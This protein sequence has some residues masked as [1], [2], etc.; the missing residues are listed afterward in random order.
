M[1]I[2]TVSFIMRRM[3]STVTPSCLKVKKRLT[4]STTVFLPTVV[5]DGF[6]R[7]DH[8]EVG[9]TTALAVDVPSHCHPKD[10]RYHR[11][12]LSSLMTPTLSSSKSTWTAPTTL[13]HREISTTTT[14]TTTKVETTTETT[15][16][17]DDDDDDDVASSIACVSSTASD[18]HVNDNNNNNDYESNDDSLFIDSTY[19]AIHDS[20]TGRHPSPPPPPPPPPVT[21]SEEWI[22]PPP[23]PSLQGG[24]DRAYRND[25][26]GNDD[27][28]LFYLSEEE[29]DTLSEEEILQRLEDVLSR[30]EQEE[31]E[32]QDELLL[33]EELDGPSSPVDWMQNRRAIL[34]TSRS[35]DG[36]VDPMSS[37]D[38]VPIRVHELMTV[39]EIQTLLEVHGGSDVI[40]VLDDVDHP[41]MGGALGM[42]IC[43]SGQRRGAG[44][45]ASSSSPANLDN[46]SSNN[47]TIDS[48]YPSSP[49]SG[50][51]NHSSYVISTLTRAL[52]EH[53]K[54]RR[55][56]EAGMLGG[57]LPTSA[58]LS[59]SNRRRNNW[60]VIDC[61]NYI[62]HILDP[63]TRRALRL[64]E[65]WSGRDPLWKLDVT[66][67]DAVEDYCA[68]YPVPADYGGQN[69]S[70]AQQQL[71]MWD[72]R[73][74]RRLERNQYA[75]SPFPSHRPVVP[76]ATKKR[77]RRAGKRRLREQRQQQQ[78]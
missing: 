46:N 47:A 76:N 3:V 69:G 42:V 17:D 36:T 19:Q 18:Y 20:K 74:V 61:G 56:H 21:M 50:G 32:E 4:T 62:V 1:P 72:A 53:L 43:S 15:M 37:T 44:A 34:G 60:E 12:F 24:V 33:R 14:R 68:K 30:M 41:R 13:V 28:A 77:D 38:I 57:P 8:S 75:A 48:Y 26:D 52:V 78:Q 40:V 31:E 25:V 45:G 73:A 10:F 11:R 63:P 58:Q 23:I 67:D 27:D 54:A 35:I 55:L 6:V 49:L 29:Q 2:A 5:C 70:T 7:T 66:N 51:G 71:S 39:D 65:L 9:D 59:N 16:N 64:E 22:P